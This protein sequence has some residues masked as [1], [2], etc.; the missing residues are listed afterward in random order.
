MCVCE[1]DGDGNSSSVQ[2][3]VRFGETLQNAA[4]LQVCILMY[5][6]DQ[7]SCLFVLFDSLVKRRRRSGCF[8]RN[9]V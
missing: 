1:T 8:S 5:D 7:Y 2:E 3:S 9:M 6:E 4:L